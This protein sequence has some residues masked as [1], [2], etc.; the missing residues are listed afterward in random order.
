[1]LSQRPTQRRVDQVNPLHQSS[2]TNESQHVRKKICLQNLCSINKIDL[3]N[4]A[5]YP[6]PEFNLFKYYRST[7]SN[8]IIRSKEVPKGI[9]ARFVKLFKS[10]NEEEFDFDLVHSEFYKF[11]EFAEEL[12]DIYCAEVIYY[13]V[14]GGGS[15]K[16]LKNIYFVDEFYS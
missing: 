16:D 1:M 14:F 15:S 11:V 5:S 9:P 6:G 8:E 10:I 12:H 2:T 3:V 7:S 4:S 13:S